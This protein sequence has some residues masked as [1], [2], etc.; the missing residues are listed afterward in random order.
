[1]HADLLVARIARAQASALERAETLRAIVPELARRLQEA[2]ARRV[3]LFGSLAKGGTPHAESD[4]D[5]CVEGIDDRALADV[6]LDLVE[7]AGAD[8]DLVRWED[9]SVRLRRRIE[10]YGIEVTSVSG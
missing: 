2:G 9:A 5:L 3:V 10:E 7:L 8:V 6:V 4:I 1:M